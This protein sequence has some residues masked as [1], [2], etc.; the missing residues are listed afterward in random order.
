MLFPDPSD[1]PVAPEE[2]AV[3]ANVDPETLLEREID[4][5]VPEHMVV[6]TGTAV[7]TGFGFTVIVIG[8]ALPEQEFAVG[9]TL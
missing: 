6:E 7:I 5:A 9:V 2:T 1:S 4:A 3:H 8:T